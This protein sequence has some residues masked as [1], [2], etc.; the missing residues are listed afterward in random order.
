MNPVTRLSQIIESM[1]TAVTEETYGQFSRTLSRIGT[2]NK[3]IPAVVKLVNMM[4]SAGQYLGIEESEAKKQIIDLLLTLSNGLAEVIKDP[5][6]AA[7]PTGHPLAECQKAFG[8]F[9]KQFDLGLLVN[10]EEM[11]RLKAVILSVDWEISDETLTGFDKETSALM[12][13]LRFHKTLYPFLKIINSLGRYLASKK[14]AAHK[15]TVSFLQSVFEHFEQVALDSELSFQDKKRLIEQDV[16]G[17]NAFKKKISSPQPSH[18]VALRPALSHVKAPKL[19]NAHTL[20]PLGSSADPEPALASV[21]PLKDAGSVASV[22][23]AQDRDVMGDL[24]N[25]KESDADRLMDRIHMSLVTGQDSAGSGSDADDPEGFENLVPHRMDQD[26][27]PEISSRLDEFFNL[28]PSMVQPVALETEVEAEA[29]FEI[30][31]DDSGEDFDETMPLFEGEEEE[32]PPE[33]LILLDPDETPEPFSDPVLFEPPAPAPLTVE[34]LELFE[35]G[36]D[37]VD[38]AMD[39][40]R[41]LL[42]ASDLDSNALAGARNDLSQLRSLWRED[43]DKCLLIDLAARL[44]ESVEDDI[45]KTD[46]ET[47]VAFAEPAAEEETESGVESEFGFDAEPEFEFEADPEPEEDPVS[48]E[49]PEPETDSQAGPEEEFEP[50]APRKFWQIFGRRRSR[51]IK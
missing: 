45:D 35:P 4:H 7:D 37:P 1:K 29:E 17:F 13:R 27:I 9:R 30:Q 28:E 12:R 42:D 5:S 19:R 15:D 50:A 51:H 46:P 24:F 6:L 11:E 39:R 43:P 16:A 47:D 34:K 40:L 3:T 14:A 23:K 18:E 26:P 21:Q 38:A 10:S 22:P 20:T 48:E 33:K 49:D 8:R 36:D 32:A 2:E 41:N 31:A 44:I 25:P